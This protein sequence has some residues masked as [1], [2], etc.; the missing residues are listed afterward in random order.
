[1]KREK[2]NAGGLRVE[3]RR[4]YDYMIGWRERYMQKLQELLEG[5]EEERALLLALLSL[6]FG[7]LIGDS[8]AGISVRQQDG[9]VLLQIQKEAVREALGRWQLQCAEEGEAYVLTFRPAKAP[10]SAE[11]EHGDQA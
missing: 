10:E 8:G 4:R 2:K 7:K 3:E 11:A 1:M 9:D 6:A 5:R